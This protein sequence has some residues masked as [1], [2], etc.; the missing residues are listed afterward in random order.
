MEKKVADHLQANVE[1]ASERKAAD[2]GAWWGDSIWKTK[3]NK[4]QWGGS[5]V[6][7]QR[8]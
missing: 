6:V 1:L 5:G 7:A 4:D 3:R 2:A 8:E